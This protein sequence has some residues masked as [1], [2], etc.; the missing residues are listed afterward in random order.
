MSSPEAT[1]RTFTRAVA[2]G[3]WQ[4]AVA[5][6]LPGGTDWNDINEIANAAEGSR[7]YMLKSWLESADETK[8]IEIVLK[9]DQA[10]S[11]KIVWKVTLKRDFSHKGLIIKAGEQQEWDATLVKTDD[12]KWLIENF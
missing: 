9:D 6:F 10:G 11:V 1:A 8:P 2:T 7:P 5:C 3:D 4:T 12:G